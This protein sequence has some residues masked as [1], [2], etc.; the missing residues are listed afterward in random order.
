MESAVLR[1]KWWISLAYGLAAG[2]IIVY[3]DNYIS[4]GEVSP[5][6]IVA[7]LLAAT[8]TA[9]ILWDERG[10]IDFSHGM[11]KF[12]RCSFDQACSWFAG[13]PPSKYI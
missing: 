7:L 3:V 6:I 2:A 9:G 4:G 12:T 8:A 5:V 11:G 13:Y 1:R 10:W